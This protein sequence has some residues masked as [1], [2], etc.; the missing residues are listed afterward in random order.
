MSETQTIE[1]AHGCT[2]AY[3]P[4]FYSREEA[5]KLLADLLAVETTPEVIRMYGRDSVTKRR[6]MQFG[7]R[8]DYNPTAK[9]PV[10]WTPLMQLVRE[11]MEQVAGP[12]D[13]GL[14]QVY[15]DGGASI[16]WHEDKGNPE[17]IASL[18]LGAERRFAFGEGKVNACRMVWDMRLP[19]GSLLLIP[20]ATNEALKHRILDERRI[21][22]PR[23]NITL[24][25]FPR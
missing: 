14:V 19:H 17:V 4:A 8:Y 18:S 25:R 20:A 23:V 24:R 9:D 16:G 21:R 13:G 3:I 7:A 5:D 12:L 6:S 15:P 10:P 22:E 11:R 1:V 2:V